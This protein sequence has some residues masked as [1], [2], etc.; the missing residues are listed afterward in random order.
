[1]FSFTRRPLY[2]HR[3]SLLVPLHTRPGGARRRENVLPILGI[4]PQFHGFQTR[5]LYRLSNHSSRRMRAL[6]REPPPPHQLNQVYRV[7]WCLRIR[8]VVTSTTSRPALDTDNHTTLALNSFISRCLVADTT[9][10][11]LLPLL[12]RIVPRASAT[13]FSF[14]T[15][16]TVN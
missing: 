2:S 1:M 13:S 7:C 15:T 12:S 10:D 5:S 14:L 3:K 9:A 11:V 4:K 8:I 6:A 16:A